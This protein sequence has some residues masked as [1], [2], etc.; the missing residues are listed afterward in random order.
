MICLHDVDVTLGGQV[1]LKNINLSIVERR[2]GIVGANGSGKST[3][4]K[5]IKG[6]IKPTAGAIT[7]QGINVQKAPRKWLAKIGYIFQ[8]PD[9]QIIFPVVEDDLAFGLKNLKMDKISIKKKVDEI[10]TAYGLEKLR[11]HNTYNL[12]GGQKQLLAIAGVLAMEPE[13]LIFDEPTTLL[14]LRNRNH[15]SKLI[16]ALPQP[17]VLATH[18]LMLLHDFERVIVLEEGQIIADDVPGKALKIYVDSMS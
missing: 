16:A 4:T 12:S 9:T 5:L 8:D 7:I 17:V 11:N 18:D 1:I 13:W 10:L 15:I 3:L 6:L 2:V 14:D